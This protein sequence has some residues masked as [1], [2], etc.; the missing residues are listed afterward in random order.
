MKPTLFMKQL[1]EYFNVY[2]PSNKKCSPNTITSYADG[3][4]T[5]FL[6]FKEGK[7]KNHYKIQY[8]DITAKTIDEY[9]LWMQNKKNYSAA[10]QKQ[11]MSA[12]SSF[13]KYASSREMD[14]LSSYNAVSQA[15]TPKVPRVCFP[16][17]TVDEVK[18]LLSAPINTGKSGYRDLTILALM[19]DSG[20]RAQE[21]CDITLGDITF[22]KTSTVKIHGK[23]NK[24]RVIPISSDVSKI[25]KKHLTESGKNLKD[26]RNDYLFPSQRS[27]GITTACIRNLVAKYV[28]IAKANNSDLFNEEAYSPHSFRHS[29]AVHML[30][31]GVPLIYIRNF[32]G[33]E[34]VQTTE[35]YLRVHQNSVSK[36]LK[37]KKVETTLQSTNVHSATT[38]QEDIPDF[39]KKVR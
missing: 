12:L 11:R 20:A 9:I 8:S 5:M 21:I 19:Y 24:T 15:Q 32:L 10:S 29:K 18:A 14:A 26:N 4:V 35:I 33:H 3:F 13:L 17:F 22:A 34:S 23:G 31:A 28:T 25:I 2:L 7:G 38:T 1:S 39:L 27:D 36:I 37:D 30:E 16:Y 6:F